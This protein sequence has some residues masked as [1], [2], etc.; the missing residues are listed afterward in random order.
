[1]VITDNSNK[2]SVVPIIGSTDAIRCAV[3]CETANP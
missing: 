1:M 2:P 3:R